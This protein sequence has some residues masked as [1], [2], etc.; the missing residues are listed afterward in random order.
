MKKLLLFAAF[1]L[2]LAT[3]Q[4]QTFNS[5]LEYSFGDNKA[6]FITDIKRADNGSV[7]VSGFF[8]GTVDFDPGPGLYNLTSNGTP[9]PNNTTMGANGF[10]QKFD[11]GGNL[12]W[13]V[14]NL[15]GDIDNVSTSTIQEVDV[16]PNGNIIV[17]TLAKD[18]TDIDPGPAV[19]YPGIGNQYPGIGVIQKLNGTNGSLIW[20]I[21]IDAKFKMVIDPNGDILIAGSYNDDNGID[22][23]PGPSVVLL[24]DPYAA[25][26]SAPFAAKYSGLDG[27]LIWSANFGFA[28]TGCAINDIDVDNT[29]KLIL[30]G[31]FKNRIVR[32]PNA[33]FSSWVYFNAPNQNYTQGFMIILN[34]D[35]STA[36]SEYY[37]YSTGNFNSQTASVD[38][39]DAGNYYIGTSSY[40]S[41]FG[42]V[43]EG[44]FKYSSG[45]FYQGRVDVPIGY[46]IEAKENGQLYLE[47]E[48][49]IN[50]TTDIDP[51]SN[52]FYPNY[53]NRT[54]LIMKW[55]WSIS[56]NPQL[57]WHKIVDENFT[58]FNLNRFYMDIGNNN[59]IYIGATYANSITPNIS[60]TNTYTVITCNPNQPSFC[61]DMYLNFAQIC[62]DT[63]FTNDNVNVCSGSNYTFSDGTT[64]NNITANF[65]HTS[66]T[67][68]AGGCD[69]AVTYA[70]NVV[71]HPITY[72]TAYVCNGD[73]YTFPN[74]FATI[75][76]GVATN[77]STITSS[78]GCD[79][80][81]V[82]HVY[83]ETA[84]TITAQVS[85]TS[86]NLTLT[87]TDMGTFEGNPSPPFN[88]TI[89][90][91]S[92]THIITGVGTYTFPI[93]DNMLSGRIALFEPNNCAADIF[94]YNNCDQS[95]CSGNS[96][97]NLLNGDFESGSSNWTQ[98]EAFL[99]SSSTSYFP[100]TTPSG[101]ETF[102]NSTTSA[103]FGGWNQGSY[104]SISQ[105]VVIDAGIT[106]TLEWWQ[107]QQN[108]CA[109]DDVLRVYI[110]GNIVYELFA[111]QDPYCGN[112]GSTTPWNFKSVDVSAYAD[113]QSHTVMFHYTQL[114]TNGYTNLFIDNISL[115]TCPGQMDLPVTFDDP[116]IN[117]ATADFGGNTSIFVNDPSGGTNQ[118]VQTTK[119]NTAQT[120]AGTSLDAFTPSGFLNAVPFT[121]T[122]TVMSIRVYSPDVGIPILLKV[123]DKTNGAIS[124]ETQAMTTVANTWEI[125]YFDFN[126]N[127]AGTPALNLANTYDLASI[128]FNFGTSGAT[129]G[130]KTYY[131]DD[132]KMDTLPCPIIPPTTVV[133]TICY[134][135]TYTFLDGNTLTWQNLPQDTIY[136]S[137]LDNGSG[138]DSIV[139]TNLHKRPNS[140]G[141]VQFPNVCFGSN[142]TYPDGFIHTNIQS[143]LGHA[144]ILT[145]QFGCDSNQLQILQ[146]QPVY[147]FIDTTIVCFGENYIA[148]D[149]TLF[150]NVQ[151][152]FNHTSN[153]S[154][155]Y[156]CDSTHQTTV[157][158]LPNY[159]NYSFDTVC[160]NSSYTFPD[161]N[162][163]N[164]L[165]S[166]TLYVIP[167][168]SFQ[169]ACDSSIYVNLHVRP[170]SQGINTSHTI[171][172]GS[173]FTFADGVTE[174]NIT[175]YTV[176]I[177]TF[178][179]QF[180]CD[181]SFIQDVFVNPNY[182][183]VQDTFNVC[184]GDD[185]TFADGTTLTIS[186]DFV[187]TSNLNTSA[188]CDSTVETTIN[189]IGIG[190][191]IQ[192]STAQPLANSKVYLIEYLPGQD[193]LFIQDSTFT[194]AN[195]DYFFAEGDPNHYVKVIPNTSFSSDLPTYYLSSAVFQYAL[196]TAC[197]HLLDFT[198]IAGQN[199]GGAGF[200]S[201]Y[202]GNGAGKNSEIGE[203]IVGLVIVIVDENGVV[204]AQTVTDEN[205]Y[206]IFDDLIC[207]IYEIWVDDATTNNN[208]APLITLEN[209]CIEENLQ[210]KLENKELDILEIT[211][212]NNLLDVFDIQLF[213]NPT[214]GLIS[215]SLDK[216]HENVDIELF[217][218]TGKRIKHINAQNI[219]EVK[220]ELGQ[221]QG[222]YLLSVSIGGV[223][224]YFKLV[225]I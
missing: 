6:D 144:S 162:T 80:V 42:P 77:S 157:Q 32:N 98:F 167:F 16:D 47:G 122:E 207:G 88:I 8:G 76:T 210:L 153:L 206:F 117:Y 29:G 158:V 180:G 185:F 25:N 139:F 216:K 188:G 138:C 159:I 78:L 37:G 134:Y 118:V 46:S 192:S 152:T 197:N 204:L 133:D 100:I 219:N 170:N 166:D 155:A 45:G 85:C 104:N 135:D 124:V 213:P 142:Y 108:G 79:S 223:V 119:N 140:I 165:Q 36:G 187:Y 147:A 14:A 64:Y 87:V 10:I 202:I 86:N 220:L 208:L 82:T 19:L 5:T 129:A 11:A 136:E 212:V 2:I 23:D 190:G 38:F 101:N 116:L 156:G 110:D 43:P 27:S 103:W 205:G 172:S 209:N 30:G 51:S 81:I 4:A 137:V 28:T 90:D 113:G 44:Y 18:S 186:N 181:S 26:S 161:G 17:S 168:T 12:D 115:Y 59:D 123:E 91:L 57:L 73:S 127:V 109:A 68:S 141:A 169:N 175:T 71:S 194:D 15:T 163:I 40:T 34:V 215:V 41:T 54:Q 89:L 97:S 183:L 13:A 148:P 31:W 164:N 151:T 53:P 96:T 52:F 7:I 221:A 218:M 39:D 3:I 75:V 106:A 92:Q 105:N 102:N 58:N 83:A 193:F 130:T 146:V 24:D 50:G 225:K 111:D 171:C 22:I 72:D 179:N 94:Y 67:T 222:T 66:Y 48:I 56:N 150:T 224:S 199:L 21:S 128:F 33:P 1:V 93:S 177:N 184:Y 35:G 201:G 145:N 69:S 182:Y 121:S 99:D 61:Y 20:A 74:G 196:E 149:G 214:T 70:V 95:I 198:T 160:H 120:W 84:P 173:D 55:D 217:D 211:T 174:T 176:H 203:P 131:W 60:S 112:A 63:I 49:A 178:T 9:W 154:T 132:V 65:N 143:N 126:D 107:R 125:L 114:G 191:T 62:I 189:T 200:I 195:G